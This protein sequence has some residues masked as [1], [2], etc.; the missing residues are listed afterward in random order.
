MRRE[1]RFPRPFL[2]CADRAFFLNISLLNISLRMR[3]DI[4]F[5]P[6]R[7]A[8]AAPAPRRSRAPFM[9]RSCA[10]HAPFVCRSCGNCISAATARRSP[11]ARHKYTRIYTR[12]KEGAFLRFFLFFVR[13][14]GDISR[15]NVRRLART[16]KKTA[17]IAKKTH[18]V[19]HE[20]PKKKHFERFVSLSVRVV[21][22]LLKSPFFFANMKCG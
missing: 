9:C 4:F 22:G 12:Q 7:F 16:V 8:P 11:F 21:Q 3:G 13:A 2:F 6:R 10:V 17:R 1:T 15:K 14:N 5:A 18:F 20:K 19:Q